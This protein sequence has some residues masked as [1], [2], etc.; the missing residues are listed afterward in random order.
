MI[1]VSIEEGTELI[2]SDVSLERVEIGTVG[3]GLPI[4]M[5]GMDSDD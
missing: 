2:F 5:D 1:G 3:I 4:V